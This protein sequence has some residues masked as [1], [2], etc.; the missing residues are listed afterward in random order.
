MVAEVPF[1]NRHL[2]FILSAALIGSAAVGCGINAPLSRQS[3]KQP[4]IEAVEAVTV[5]QQARDAI[6][7][8]PVEF[9][10]HLPAAHYSWERAQLFFREHTTKSGF[11]AGRSDTLIL[12]NRNTQ[13]DPMI[14]EVERH[15][16]PDGYRFILHCA[17]KGSV[18]DADAV[19][20]SCRNV[21]RF[22]KDG[23]LE[24]SFLPAR[25]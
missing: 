13:A 23:V 25:S 19:N 9:I 8:T 10:A 24:E 18:A 15:I 22:I 1:R 21:A 7:K 11:I 16:I 12:S 14:F 17:P 6:S 20:L 4:T 3:S 5:E 2:R